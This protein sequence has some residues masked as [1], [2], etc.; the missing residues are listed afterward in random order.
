MLGL[1]ELKWLAMLLSERKILFGTRVLSSVS[2]FKGQGDNGNTPSS[3]WTIDK[4]NPRLRIQATWRHYQ[5]AEACVAKG[6]YNRDYMSLDKSMA[7]A[8][9]E[10]KKIEQDPSR[11]APATPDHVTSFVDAL[12]AAMK[13]TAPDASSPEKEDG[14]KGKTT[15]AAETPNTS[16]LG[17]NDPSWQE[18]RE[19]WK[20][21]PTP[22]MW[23]NAR[24]ETPPGFTHKQW[25]DSMHTGPEGWAE[26]QK[27][28]DDE[29][30]E[31]PQCSSRS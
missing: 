1:P 14:G 20:K 4:S 9:A 8:I 5:F 18:V 16:E 25:F 7:L 23:W 10:A 31:G 19:E 29:P 3:I 11:E 6:V 27:S 2:V 15:E 22:V 30:E 17:A 26:W 28:S 13:S 12:A 24:E 21:S